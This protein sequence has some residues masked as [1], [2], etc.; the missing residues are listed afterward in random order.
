MNKLTNPVLR[1]HGGKY[2]LAKWIMSFFPEHHCYVEPFSGAA[3]ILLQKARSHGEVYNDL[4][5]D[6]F[7][8][9]QVLRNRELSAQ[10]IELCHLTPYSRDEFLLS[11]EFTDCVIERARRT[12]VS[13]AMGFGSGAATFHP[14]G[15]RSEAKRAPNTCA[16]M[17]AK[18]PPLLAYVCERLQAVNIEN[19][20]ATECIRSHDSVNTLFYVDPPYVKETRWLRNNKNVYQH[21]MSFEEHQTLLAQLLNVKGMVVLSGYET[22]LYNDTLVGWSLHKKQARCSAA[23]GTGMRT[24]CIWV[25]PHACEK[26]ASKEAA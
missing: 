16:H 7:N 26:L 9:F 18:Y 23:N 2:R 4:D 22:E 8:L 25:N 19:R 10:L 12:V 24:E 6:I 15:F 11:Y 3:S 14:T 17:W 20:E 5:Q 21:E 1:Y 13:S